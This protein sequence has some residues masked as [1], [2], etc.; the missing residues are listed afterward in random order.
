MT[1]SPNINPVRQFI[2]ERKILSAGIIVLGLISQLLT[3]I[4]P[5]S[6]GK[7]YELVFHF[8]S[9]RSKFLGFIPEG[10]WNT[11]PEFLLI[12][13]ILIILRFIFYFLYQYNL[14]KESEIFIKEVKD[15]LF[16]HQVHVDF[17]TYKEKGTGKY[18]LRYSGDINSLKNLYLKGSLSVLIDIFMV[19][20]SFLLLFYL[21][22]RGA[23]AIIVISAIAFIAIRLV[24]RKVE[25]F[26]LNKR[27]KTSG[28]L[29]F[30]NRTL[31]SILSV[32]LFNKQNIELKKYKKKSNDIMQEAI[33]YDKWITINNGFISFV[34]YGIL[35]VI[36]FLFYYDN[37]G[38]EDKLLSANLIS[39]ILLF[40][41]IAPVL[42]RLFG[43]ET[44]YKL[45]NISLNKLLNI[46]AIEKEN[47][48]EGETL[49]VKNPRL[50]FENFKI[51]NSEPLNYTSGKLGLN[52]LPVPKTIEQ[53][54]IITAVTR[55]QENYGGKI[56]INGIDIKQFSPHSIRE[57]VGLVS[58]RLPLIGRT[59]YEAITESRIERQ[60]PEVEKSLNEIQGVFPGISYFS[61]WDK[62]GENGSRLTDL[63]YELLCFIRGMLPNKRILLMDN[64][65]LLESIYQDELNEILN[66]QNATIIKFVT[67]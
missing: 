15:Q 1:L 29:A 4:I 39:F 54:S 60:K 20:S 53:I 57:N 34:Q 37:I 25:K 62:I 61:L 26:S 23:I 56:K 32:I 63:Q 9:Q 22:S 50:V 12:F 38:S 5:V 11:V 64:F 18:L 42:R 46:L 44:V 55:I 28:Q 30:V 49:D 31:N 6:I 10:I 2:K 67:Q 48:T 24:N 41:T 45:G 35:A 59:V 58:K 21:H 14:F 19:L 17:S 16:D 36:F 47:L 65:V 52:I 3:I 27:N 13:F 7:Y 40:I 8:Q 43:L 66:K 33:E 51:G